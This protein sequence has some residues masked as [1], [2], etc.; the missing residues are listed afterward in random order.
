MKI[1]QTKNK[2]VLVALL[3]VIV[4]LVLV[5]FEL[6]TNPTH[7]S[8]MRLM[9]IHFRSELPRYKKVDKSYVSDGEYFKFM[10]VELTIDSLAVKKYIEDNKNNICE[11]NES[12]YDELFSKETQLAIK[13]LR[14][15]KGSILFSDCAVF[16]GGYGFVPKISVLYPIANSNDYKFNI[17]AFAS[18]TKRAKSVTKTWIYNY[19]IPS[20]VKTNF[21]FIFFKTSHYV[22]FALFFIL[23]LGIC[24][25]LIFKNTYKWHK[26]ALNFLTLITSIL[27]LSTV[28]ANTFNLSFIK[29]SQ[30]FDYFLLGY[31]AL[32]F[33]YLLI[34]AIE[35]IVLIIKHRKDENVLLL[36]T[37]K[38][39]PIAYTATFLAVTVFYVLFFNI[40]CF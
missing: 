16:I 17:I 11:P 13:K 2:K 26:T 31:I 24:I 15:K 40:L 33:I 12:Y 22:G 27:G 38:W 21:P 39:I 1:A 8:D 10:N 29:Y 36:K 7:N 14:N 19:R 6:K 23:E 37:P 25:Y 34:Y 9:E 3:L 35:K 28:V 5:I 20:E 18:T 4:L 30:F 32:R